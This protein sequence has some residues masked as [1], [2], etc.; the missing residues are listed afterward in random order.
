MYEVESI[1]QVLEGVEMFWKPQLSVIVL[2]VIS[3]VY[4]IQVISHGK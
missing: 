2:V 3:E 4:K 1:F